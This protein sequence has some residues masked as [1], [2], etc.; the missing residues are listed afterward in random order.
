[1]LS[2]ASLALA[3]YFDAMSASDLLFRFLASLAMSGVSYMHAL[4]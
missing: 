4:D 1:M 3:D 2:D